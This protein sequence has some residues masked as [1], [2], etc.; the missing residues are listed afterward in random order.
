MSAWQAGTGFFAKNRTLIEK[1]RNDV[2]GHFGETASR[3]AVEQTDPSTSISLT[4]ES[5]VQNQSWLSVGFAGD[6]AATALV[7]HAR[8]SD[9]DEKAKYAFGL[10]VEGLNHAMEI[11]KAVLGPSVWHRLGK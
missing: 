10:M 7:R 8:G 9:S 2:G 4:I 11:V 6:L 3:Y 1:I 5:N